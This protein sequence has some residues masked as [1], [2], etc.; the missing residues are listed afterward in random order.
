MEK[1]MFSVIIPAYNAAPFIPKSVASVL[2]Q[3]VGNF[4]IIIV[5]DGSTDDSRAIVE[6]IIAE[7]KDVKIKLICQA[8]ILQIHKKFK[9]NTNILFAGH[10]F[11]QNF[12]NL[13]SIFCY[14]FRI[15]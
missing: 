8:K 6:R 1:F 14:I 12:F 13:L 10:Y 9:K 7:C 2:A 3:T 4:E 11:L 15:W 5:D